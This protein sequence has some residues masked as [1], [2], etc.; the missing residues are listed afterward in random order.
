MDFELI[1]STSTLTISMFGGLELSYG[2]KKICENTN[3]SRKLWNLLAYMITHRKRNISQSEFIDIL[4]SQSECTNPESALKNLQY[5]IRNLLEPILSERESFIIS[6]R[7]SYHW[8]NTFPCEID[9]ELFEGYI[10]K[11]NHLT[12]N[13]TRILYY[14]KAINLYKG[15]F[16]SNHTNELW[17]VPLN[18]HFHNLFLD[19]TRKLS[20]LLEEENEFDKMLQICTHGIQIDYYDEKL[21]LSL[22]KALKYQGNIN[23]ALNHYK[24][25][26]N[27]LYKYLGVRPS[28][29]LRMF[30]TE[31]KKSLC[32]FEPSL[33][34]I[35]SELNNNSMS[36]GA[37]IC[38]YSLFKE[39]YRLEQRKIERDGRFAHICLLTITLSNG[40]IP[41]NSILQTAMERLLEIITC[42]LRKYDIVSRYSS[43]QYILMLPSCNYIDCNMVLK[44]IV[45]YFFFKNTKSLL[46]ISY[47]IEE[48][49]I[50]N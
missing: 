35:Q 47:T 23:T 18:T 7:N 29:D 25:F 12:D 5:R 33:N 43:S 21:H 28:E 1:E 2:D 42:C 3:R 4:W 6:S 48:I 31:L 36:S 27:L 39:I 41:S 19:A 32:N 16:L 24:T 11:A 9:I 13:K 50:Q 38:D 26:S 14:T 34:I 37:F 30:Y 49:K 17:I 8:N 40:E 15:D 10:K 46:R 22:L 45:D 44:R 20:D